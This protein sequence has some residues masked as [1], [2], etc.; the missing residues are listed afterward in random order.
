MYGTGAKKY[1]NGVG[2]KTTNDDPVERA[3]GLTQYSVS[4]LCPS[5]H[6]IGSE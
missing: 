4:E 5:S 6:R 1:I 2:N 3:A